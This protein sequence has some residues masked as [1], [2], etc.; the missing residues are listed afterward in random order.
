VSP[1]RDV[2]GSVS[3][4]AVSGV[5]LGLAVAV[6]AC[7][8]PATGTRAALAVAKA[9]EAPVSD[10]RKPVR[11]E[12]PSASAPPVP[13]SKASSPDPSPLCSPD[14]PPGSFAAAQFL[15]LHAGPVRS[16][17][18]GRPPRAAIWS[19]R[20]VTLLE[21]DVARE[22]PAPRLPEGA[23]VDVFFGRDDQPRLMGFAPGEP[24][25]K[26]PVYLRFRGGAFRPEPGELGPLAAPRGALY[27]VLGFD[28]PEV[29]CR[30]RELCLVK[31][32]SGW[33]RVAAHDAPARVVL[34]GES[35]FAL[36]AGHMERLGKDG[37]SALEPARAFERPLDAFVAPNG[38]LWVADRSEAGLFRLKG[39]RWE[40]VTSPISKPHAV[41]GRSERAVYVVGS[42]GAAE[43]D[44]TRFRCVRGVTGPLHLGLAVGD[45]LWLAGESGVYRS[46][47]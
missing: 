42:N 41:F 22:L 24:G 10:P 14:A 28:D 37:W 12:P 7:S 16:A 18:V 38:E 5:L 31:R 6:A 43:F 9:S 3:W 27:G 1:I 21:G 30:P 17:A 44:G 33:R 40:A 46:Q 19:G 29:V 2:I 23:T 26:L 25:E 11:P 34:R 47:R 4:N 20:T 32:T 36:H 15:R 45:D 8:K 13:S 39:G 35:V